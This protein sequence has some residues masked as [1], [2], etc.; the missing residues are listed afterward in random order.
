MTTQLRRWQARVR[1][2]KEELLDLGEMRPGTLSEQYNVCGKATCRCKDPRNPRKHGPYYQISYSH[3]GRSTT[4]F[5]KRERVAEVRRQLGN[6]ARFK[7]LTAEWV[8]LS[9]RMANL[10]RQQLKG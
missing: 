9:L 2:I 4:E 10:R 1:R 5:V 7:K 6:Y 8:S 3:G